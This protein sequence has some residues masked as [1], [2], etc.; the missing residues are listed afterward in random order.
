MAGPEHAARHPEAALPEDPPVPADP[1][2]PRP[3]GSFWR[4]VQI[5]AALPFVCAGLAVIA[6]IAVLGHEIHEHLDGLEDWIKGLGFWGPVVFVLLF[7]V[8]TSVFI[9]DSLLS[10]VA[11]VLFGFL[12]GAGAVIA[13][14]VLA[15]AIQYGLA[16]SVLGG[17]VDRA[18]SSRPQ[19]RRIQNAVRRDELRL[20]LLIRLTPLSP[21]LGSYVLGATGVRFGSFLTALVALFPAYMLQVYFGCA[22]KHV[23]RMT[24]RGVAVHDV[25]ILG[26]LVACGVVM[27]LVTRTARRALAKAEAGEA[28]R[29]ESRE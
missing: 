10:I 29:V 15:G 11:G 3:S 14:G 17:A 22:G 27:W 26:G 13:G 2:P 8:L 18:V 25:L 5:R 12:W 24:G 28:E 23:M 6:A 21:T 20:Q 19:L 7:V 16:R 1:R 4:G 9:P